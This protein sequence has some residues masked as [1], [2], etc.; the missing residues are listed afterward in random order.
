MKTAQINFSSNEALKRHI[1]LE[2][3][4]TYIAAALLLPIV[5]VEKGLGLKIPTVEIGNDWLGLVLNALGLGT[6]RAG[7]S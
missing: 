4:L 6:Q 3:Y 5:F 2:G 1:L 7:K